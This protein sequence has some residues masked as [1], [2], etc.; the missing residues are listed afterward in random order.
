MDLCFHLLHNTE[1]KMTACRGLIYNTVD[2]YYLL[3]AIKLFKVVGLVV[4]SVKSGR[5]RRREVF[6]SLLQAD[7]S[8]VCQ[9]GQII[10]YI[11]AWR[12]LAF[13][14]IIVLSNYE[15]KASLMYGRKQHSHLKTSTRLPGDF[16][17]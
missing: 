7:V 17:G 1:N 14:I 3:T 15:I 6:S 12:M 2:Y 4:V 16:L 8:A 5:V 10:S 11:P 9:V 13:L